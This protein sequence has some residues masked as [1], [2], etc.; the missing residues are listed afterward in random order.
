[1]KAKKSKS[2]RQ[3]FITRVYDSS[4][5]WESDLWMLKWIALLLIIIDFHGINKVPITAGTIILPEVLYFVYA[6]LCTIFL[7]N[8][9]SF[10]VQTFN[11]LFDFLFFTFF[12]YLSLSMFSASSR[13][14]VLYF[15]PVIY[16]G[17]WFKWGFALIFATLISSTY[18]LLNYSILLADKEEIFIISGIKGTLAPVVAVYF[19]I[20]FLVIFFKRVILKYLLDIDEE[21]EKRAEKLEQEKEYTRSLLKDKIDGFIVIDE[22]GFVTE[23]NQLACE[24][25]GYDERE[26]YSKN[27]KE[28]YPPG[29]SVSIIKELRESP[30]GTIENFRTYVINKKNN[31]KIPI[32]VSAAFLFD[33]KNL[34]LKEALENGKR[35]PNLGYFRDLRTED[36]F[37]R[38][39]KEIAFMKDEK[40]LST[41]ITSSI[42]RILKAEVCSILIYNRMTDRLEISASFGMP[43]ILK[44][45]VKPIQE[46]YE[47]ME[48]MAGYV[49]STNRTLNVKGIDITNKKL[50][51]ANDNPN[52]ITVKWNY[53]KN[54]AEYSKY[55]DFQHFLATPLKIR[56]EAFGVIKVLNKYLN[57]KEL[58]KTGFHDEDQ[59]KLERISNQVSILV[60][61]FRNKERFEAISK[62]SIELNERLDL[63][64]GDFLARVARE[65]V[66][67]MRFT[68]CF[69]YV[70]EENKL[71]IKACEGL[72]GN[73]AGN[74]TYTLEIGEGISGEVAKTGVHRMISDI[75]QKEKEF[76]DIDIL[77]KE[78]LTSLLSIPINYENKTFGVINCCTRREHAFTQEEIQIIQTFAVYTAVAVRN[79]KRVQEL[80]AVNEIGSELVKPFQLEKLFDHILEKAKEISGADRLCIK[81]YNERSGEITTIGSLNCE[82]HKQIKDYVGKLGDDFISK[83]IKNGEPIIIPCYDIK[84]ERLD[85]VPKKELFAD[86]KSCMIVPIKIYGKVFGVI[87]LDSKRQNAFNEND[88]LILR[89]FSNQVAAAIRNADFF[90]KLQNVKETFPRISELNMDI[91][92]VLEKIVKVAAEVLETDVLVLFR[93]DEKT[94]KFILPPIYIGDLRHKEALETEKMFLKVPLLLIKGGESH[95]ADHSQTDSVMTSQ[96]KVLEKGQLFVKREEIFSSAGIVLKVGKDIVGIMFINYRRPHEFNDDERQLIEIFASYIAIAIQNVMHFSEKKVADTMHTIGKIASNFAH[97]M[98]NDMATIKLYAGALIDGVK[99]GESQYLPLSQIMEKISKITADIDHL[100][101]ASKLVVQGKKYI[102]MKEFIDELEVELLPDLEIRKIEFA[103]EIPPGIPRIE[104]DPIQV[105]MVLINLAQNSFDA[106]PEGG[107]ISL[108]IS[109]S[110]EAI[111]LTW[112]DSG[113]GISPEDAPRVFDALWTKKKR[114]YGLGLFHA[115]AIIEEH[116]GSISVDTQYKGG[117]RFLIEIPLRQGL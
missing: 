89:T 37:D 108:L 104:I 56:D 48:G 24:L 49:F 18:F 51:E 95:Y 82:W 28:I 61:K 63:P 97:K 81:R 57:D 66:Y 87:H 16:C 52:N 36:V 110:D 7:R 44:C 67:S 65:A 41:E 91:H 76:K 46:Q 75:N 21:L 26:I 60:E 114:G 34:N 100:E 54:F 83:T 30:D 99:P 45:L 38:I 27:V 32:Q 84:S 101:K 3:N 15:I 71:K 23:V 112:T 9:L 80:L 1:M 92:Q 103:F 113:C 6:L 4:H 86:M 102:D 29:V 73:Y 17:Y 39:G 10:K 62:I 68:A 42:S 13:I 40:E 64:L 106:M 19:L 2:D 59:I 53:A 12:Q 74:E 72:A 111:L 93:Y 58:D 70:E 98:K 20:T 78:N 50:V 35:F 14:Y 25:F 55:K 94:Q 47:E 109:R 79:R 33:R 69:I 85:K 8:K 88:L 115:K 43:R 5:K 77:T 11:L 117:A 96:E 22:A 116:R 105:K 31:E 90:N 107:K